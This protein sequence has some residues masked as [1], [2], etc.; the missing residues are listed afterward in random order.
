[1]LATKK[2][3]SFLSIT[4]VSHGSVAEDIHSTLENLAQLYTALQI[5]TTTVLSCV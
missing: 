2:S 5:F 3:A 4:R 1:M